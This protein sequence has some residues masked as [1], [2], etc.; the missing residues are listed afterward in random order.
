M[1]GR[2][3]RG[4]PGGSEMEQSK[5][6]PRW[7]AATCSSLTGGLPVKAACLSPSTT[8]RVTVPGVGPDLVFVALLVQMAYETHL[9]KNWP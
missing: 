9:E 7:A 4:E 3:E 1:Q 6:S 8:L 5:I 2:M